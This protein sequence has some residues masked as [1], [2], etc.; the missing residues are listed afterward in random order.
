MGL[1]ISGCGAW[2]VM[3]P[4]KRIESLPVEIVGSDS[5]CEVTMSCV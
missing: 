5:N 3:L 1:D 4:G 2:M